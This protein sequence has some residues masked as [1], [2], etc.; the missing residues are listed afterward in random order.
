[1]LLKSRD[2]RKFLTNDQISDALD[3]A[4]YLG[5]A[6]KQVELMANKT[7]YEREGRL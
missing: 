7:Q 4:K 5:T 3:P 2:V 1:V 6:V